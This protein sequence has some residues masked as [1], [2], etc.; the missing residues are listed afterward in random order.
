MLTINKSEEAKN[1]KIETGHGPTCFT[2][3]WWATG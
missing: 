2:W 1:K 3:Y